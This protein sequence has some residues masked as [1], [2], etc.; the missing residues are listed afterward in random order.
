M[1]IAFRSGCGHQRIKLSDAGA[2]PK[3]ESVSLGEPA[4]VPKSQLEVLQQSEL[5]AAFGTPFLDGLGSPPTL[6]NRV[7]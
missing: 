6:M 3:M 5:H 4:K 7:S 2:T 1:P